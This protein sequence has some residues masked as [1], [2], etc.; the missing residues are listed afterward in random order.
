MV[1]HFS[2][3]EFDDGVQPQIVPAMAI[4]IGKVVLLEPCVLFAKLH[5]RIPLI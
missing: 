4:R 1:V 2:F 3:S 5:P